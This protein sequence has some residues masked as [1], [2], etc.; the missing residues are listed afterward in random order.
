M[1]TRRDVLRLAG[2]VPTAALL[3][4]CRPDGPGTARQASA[5]PPD[6]LLVETASGFEL[7]DARIGRVVMQARQGAVACDGSAIVSGGPGA[8]ALATNVEVRGR[9]GALVYD[10]DVA[11]EL[12]ARVVSPGGSFVA[13]ASGSPNGATPYRPAPR[14]RTTIVVAGRS[15]ERQ[16]LTLPGCVEPEA[17]SPAG[18]FLY[19]L[20]YLPP[21]QPERYRV[22]M[23]DLAA[24]GLTPLYTRDK[25][26]IPT[27][28][29]EQ[30]RGQGRQ[31]VYA[32]ARRLLFTLY[33][34]QPDHLHTRDL[35]GGGARKGEPH[36][37]AF[38]HTLSLEASFAYCIDLPAPF[39]EGPAE[40]H[41][42]AIS[43]RSEDPYVVDATSGTVARLNSLNL[44]VA[45]VAKFHL[46]S[47]GAT[48][49][50]AISTDDSRVFIGTGSV[51]LAVD[52]T[53]LATVSTWAVPAAVRGLGVSADGDRLWVGQ[54][55]RVVAL[56]VSSGRE[57][58]SLTLPGLKAL[59][60]VDRAT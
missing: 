53:S 24:G 54:P 4:A 36:V 59:S 33:T 45:A 48:A 10:V 7:L 28:A 58:A 16:R 29:E 13:L 18:D 9:G 42:I 32:A 19:V 21:Q 11:G 20:D 2:A 23:V 34:H 50:A 35:L 55:D 60:Q 40:G 44:T 22:R 5:G 6:L 30:M 38:V 25:K 26:V 57:V 47:A 51:V 8:D 31:A 56:D 15:G 46:K 41:A 43:P 1:T 12:G 14:A 39:G 52:T 17:F 37:H 3:A 49:A 27:G